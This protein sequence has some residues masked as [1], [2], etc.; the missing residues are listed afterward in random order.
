MGHDEHAEEL[1]QPYGEGEAPRRELGED[2]PA[3][4]PAEREC[5]YGQGQGPSCGSCGRLRLGLRV[6]LGLRQRLGVEVEVEVEVV[7][8]I[9]WERSRSYRVLRRAELDRGE[10]GFGHGRD[11][12]EC[13]EGLQNVRGPKMLC[14]RPTC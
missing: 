13:V 2:V 4:R 1:E 10:L 3:D 11:G 8:V 7:V 6:G 5:G 12:R 14:M 9:G